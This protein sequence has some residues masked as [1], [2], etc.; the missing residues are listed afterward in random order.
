MT[1]TDVDSAGCGPLCRF[2]NADRRNGPRGVALMWRWGYASAGRPE[3]GM[4]LD[5]PHDRLAI[6]L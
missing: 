4:V 1:E 2:L 3:G 5:Q 6:L